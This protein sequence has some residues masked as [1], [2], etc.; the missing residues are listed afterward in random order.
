M[1]NY[2]LNID[3]Q[4]PGDEQINKHKN[5]KKLLYNHEHATQPLYKWYL[6][7]YKNKRI[8]LAILIIVVLIY[9]IVES[10]L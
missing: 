5:F 2:R 4:D 9:I 7:N 3:K 1:T 6:P 8:F 10:L